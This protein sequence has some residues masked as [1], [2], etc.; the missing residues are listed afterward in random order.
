MNVVEAC[1]MP[2]YGT[3]G[4]R[5]GYTLKLRIVT[6]QNRIFIR[7]TER[8]RALFQSTIPVAVTFVAR[9]VHP[10]TSEI[11]NRH[12]SNCALISYVLFKLSTMLFRKTEERRLRTINPCKWIL[13]FQRNKSL[14]SSKIFPQA[15]EFLMFP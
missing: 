3:K 14:L 6:C 4:S 2:S 7:P 15:T 13:Q 12:M 1:F 11:M 9:L 8:S 10:R 5:M